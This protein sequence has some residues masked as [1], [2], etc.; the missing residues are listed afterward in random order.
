MVILKKSERYIAKFVSFFGYISAA[1][2][3]L[4]MVY[5]A[6]DA[7]MRNLNRSFVGSNELIVNVVVI[8][9]FLGIGQTSVNN[10]Q[11]KIDVLKKL[12]WLD[13][14]TLTI[15][16]VMYIFSGIAAFSQAALAFEMNLS[17]SFLSIP[18]GPF[19]IVTGI[20]LILCGLGVI[21]VELRFIISLLE[22][23]RG[24]PV[25]VNQEDF[26]DAIIEESEIS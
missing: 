21:C 13:H 5:V 22:K 19:L 7:I 2:M 4:M 14:I 23:K 6:A 10:A 12:Q 18:R 20:G 24:I 8:V 15:S 25:D 17:S 16:C 1:V 26:V 11:I 9:I 3:I